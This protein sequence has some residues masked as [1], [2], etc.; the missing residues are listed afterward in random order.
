MFLGRIAA[1]CDKRY[2]RRN[3][4]SSCDGCLVLVIHCQVCQTVRSL[5]LFTITGFWV[6]Q[7][8]HVILDLIIHHLGCPWLEPLNY[9]SL[10]ASFMQGMSAVET[11]TYFR[12]LQ[13]V[14]I[15][16]VRW[17]N[18][19]KTLEIHP[20]FGAKPPSQSGSTTPKSTMRFRAGILELF[21]GVFCR[22]LLEH[23][24]YRCGELTMTVVP[25]LGELLHV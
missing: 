6:S 5:L 8:S 3:A 25:H 2:Q 22:T 15:P 16:C 19:G 24:P 4:T 9:P 7:R 17:E 1:T 12:N 14:K 20:A 10:P 13:K 18:C 11:S 21:P 23:G